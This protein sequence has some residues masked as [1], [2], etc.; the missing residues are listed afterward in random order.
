MYV[1]YAE[2]IISIYSFQKDS[3]RSRSN[4]LDAATPVL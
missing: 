1:L 2:K 3:D 4:R